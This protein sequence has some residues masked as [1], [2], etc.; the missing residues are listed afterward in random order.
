MR[1]SLVVA[2]VDRTTELQRFLA[3]LAVQLY[4]DFELI[5]V[6]QNLDDR[7]APVLAPYDGRFAII[8]LHSTRGLSRARNVG[9]QRISGDVVAFPDDDCWYPQ[10]ML[11]R[12]ARL[13][14][15]HADLGG[16]TGRSVDIQGET[17]GDARF[18][19]AS[20]LVSMANVWKRACSYT[21][22]LQRCVI[23][24]IGD[25]DETLGLGAGTLWE[26]GEDIDY[27]LRA[28]QAG[29]KICYYPDICVFHP[30]PAQLPARA[31]KYGAGIGRVWRK[32]NFPRW[33]VAYHL[34]RPL[35]GSILHLVLGRLSKTHYHWRAFCG[36]LRGWL[37]RDNFQDV[38]GI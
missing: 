12:V 13:W 29:F 34:M 3:A 38:L 26:G 24:T 25:F 10:E 18:D 33:F 4:R 15:T 16:L 36:R 27:P 17:S 31:Y 21:M 20:G 9:L 11:V 5:V 7:L 14:E 30:S 2:T 35:A 28:I 22:F 23:E 1:F 8:H 19:R 37:S 32:H 6:D